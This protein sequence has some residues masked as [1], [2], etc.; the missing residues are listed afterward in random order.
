M[1]RLI[2]RVLLLVVLVGTTQRLFAADRWETLQAI[3][4]IENPRDSALPGTHGE[5]GAYQ[6]RR[7]TWRMHSHQ[8]FQLA[9]Y[10]TQSDEVACAHYEW[11]RAG[12][13]RNGF[14][15]TTYN[16]ALAWNAG[17]EATVNGR[18]SRA[19]RSYAERVSN[20]V[21][22]LKRAESAATAATAPAPVAGLQIR[23]R[24]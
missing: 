6:F 23:L 24:P 17:L 15:D 13:V 11:L 1:F 3:H 21:R 16:I 7:S 14:S 20:I 19:S 8:P 5:L 4:L 9:L 2:A 12:L 10:R 18:T 22:D